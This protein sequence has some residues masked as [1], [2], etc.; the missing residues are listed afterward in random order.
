MQPP[1]P[2]P[3]TPRE[4]IQGVSGV[5]EP[6]WGTVPGSAT[7]WDSAEPRTTR[8]LAQ[9]PTN[10]SVDHAALQDMGSE[11]PLWPFSCYSHSKGP[12]DLMGDVSY[13]EVRLSHYEVRSGDATRAYA[14]SKS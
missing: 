8:F 14:T 4:I 12:N 10:S 5:G 3:L 6:P 1:P 7:F 13:E 9:P 2:P 11:R